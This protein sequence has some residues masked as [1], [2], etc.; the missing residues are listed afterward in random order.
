VVKEGRRPFWYVPVKLL[1]LQKPVLLTKESTLEDCI[2][3]MQETGLGCIFIVDEKKNLVG[4]FTDQDVMEHFVASSLPGHTK[5]TKV[6]K[7]K[8]IT[9]PASTDVAHAL[10]V[11]H[12]KKI[13]HL[14]VIDP[15]EGIKGLLSIRVL[16]DYIAENVPKAVLN[17]PPDSTIVSRGVEGG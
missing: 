10:E 6:L 17:I 7:K 13:R 5:I 8:P 1:P 9:I 14:P 15:E 11:F 16:M 12:E 2:R 3:A 4:L